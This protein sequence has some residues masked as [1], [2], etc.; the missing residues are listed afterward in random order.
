ML[1]HFPQHSIS[2]IKLTVQIDDQS[3]ECTQIKFLGTIIQETLDWT[4]HID[5]IS[6]KISQT[7]A[8]M[9]KLKHL[10]PGHTLKTV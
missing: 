8:V 4:P 7:L 10:L 3:I 2:D 1:F 6:N 5:I 9:N